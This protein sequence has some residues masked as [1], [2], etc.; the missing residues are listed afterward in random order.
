[1]L[2]IR[3]L[4]AATFTPLKADGSLALD[5]IGGFVD[6]LI[7]KG[8]AGLYVVGST[9]EGV[10][11]TT[12]E[13]R[14]VA[15]EFVQAAGGRVPVIIQVGHNSVAEAAG[16]ARH[17]AEV[18]ATAISAAP[19]SY[20]PM[21]SIDQLVACIEPITA[22]ADVPFYYYHIPVRTG[23]EVDLVELF[24]RVDRIPSF[25]GVKFTSP[26]VFDFQAA[27]AAAGDRFELMYGC[28]E[29]LL[30]A[31][32]VGAKAAVGTTYNFIG[33]HYQNI[34]ADYEAGDLDSAADRQGQAVALIR[35]LNSHGGLPLMKALLARL[36]FDYGPVRPPFS[37]YSDRQVQV[38]M[39]LIVAKGLDTIL[40]STAED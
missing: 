5:R 30:S 17:A 18:G 22:A 36:G 39:D 10:S 23:V 20:F 32:V 11:L 38:A 9:G 21:D 3:G 35:I 24:E 16:L 1:M 14:A 37:T 25:A 29:M 6:D 31:L 34:I 4:V 26:R 19:P 28:D 7:R 8:I 2:D 27:R 13:R 12:E 40:D 15:A 33:S